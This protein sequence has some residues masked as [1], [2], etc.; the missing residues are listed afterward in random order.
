M[1]TT[2][3]EKIKNKRLDLNMTQD[4]LGEKIGVQKS[5]VAKYESGRVE[6]LKRSTIIK[7]AQALNTSPAYL[8]GWEEEVSNINDVKSENLEIAS[9]MN[10]DGKISDIMNEISEN[11]SDE[12]KEKTLDFIKFLKIKKKGNQ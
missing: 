8:M 6:N 11:F 7:L 12:D 2:L 1:G 9:I 4:E 10:R 5:A 3:G